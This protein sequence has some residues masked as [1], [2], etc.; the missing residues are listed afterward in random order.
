MD[1]LFSAETENDYGRARFKAF[2]NDIRSMIA[3]RPN[4]LVSFDQVKRSLKTFGENYRG[5]QI[6]PIEKI[7]GSATL[8][9]HD[10]DSAFLPRQARTKSRWRSIDLAHYTDVG[11][12]PVELYQI[13]DVYFVRDGHHR[14]SVARERGQGYIDAQV[15]E[16]KTHVP[17]TPD[18]LASDLEIVGEYSDFI[19]K[20]R[21]DKLRPAQSIRFSEPGGYGRLVEHIAVHRYFLGEEAKAKIPFQDAVVSWYDHLYLPVVTTIREHNILR[22]FPRR[23][24]ADLYLWIADHHYYLHE[25]N[26]N[27]GLEDAAVDF[28]AQY[29]QRLDKRLLKAVKQAVSEIIGVESQPIVGTFLSEPR[30]V[31]KDADSESE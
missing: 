30:Q 9:Y 16:V 26:E 5:V 10:F 2:W 21:I 17:V 13:G 8:R 4:E 6:V 25:Q 27:V 11:L 28:A 24:E 29:S 18:L 12:P 15:I 1:K 31:N 22:D 7:V 19:E 14:I 3:R 20:T 23:T